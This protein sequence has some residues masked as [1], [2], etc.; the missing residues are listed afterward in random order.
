MHNIL[1][2]I[3]GKS[4]TGEF[5]ICSLF[6]T[7]VLVVRNAVLCKKGCMLRSDVTKCTDRVYDYTKLCRWYEPCL[8]LK[9]IEG[10]L[11]VG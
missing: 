1:A 9:H 3:S 6:C 7:A 11:T 4:Y 8:R 5:L 10:V 2:S